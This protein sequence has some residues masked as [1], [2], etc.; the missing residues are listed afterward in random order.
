[1]KL[2]NSMIVIIEYSKMMEIKVEP[3]HPHLGSLQLRF[4][5][6]TVESEVSAESETLSPFFTSWDRHVLLLRVS[7]V[8][9][10]ANLTPLCSFL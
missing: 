4:V 9:A 8:G 3:W 1:M 10:S 6:V 5:W 7:R 2:H